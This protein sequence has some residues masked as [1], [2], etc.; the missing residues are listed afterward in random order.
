MDTK[1]QQR[2]LGLEGVDH[3][4]FWVGNA[5]AY[6]GFLAANFGFSILAYAG[7][8]TGLR[9]RASYVLQQG[10]I[11]FVVTGS[12]LPDTAI[13]DHVR[14]HGDGVR[15][16]AL[17]VR[18]CKDAY[19]QAL[20][21]GARGIAEPEEQSDEH[22]SIV[23]A[24]IA[25]YGD[26]IHTFVERSDYRGIF[27]PGYGPP[28]QRDPEGAPVDLEAI[29]HVVA[30]VPEMEPWVRYYEQIMGFSQLTH[31]TDEDVSTEYSALMSK[32]VEDGGGKIV[33]PINEPATGKRKS[34]IEE[35]LEYYRGPGVQHIAMRTDDIVS[36]VRSLRARGVRFLRVPKT[37]YDE[38]RERMTG[39]DLPWEDLAEL[40]ILVDR[41]HDGHLLQIFTEN[42]C[43]RPTVFF[44][45]IQREGSRGFGVG[46]FKA[47][48]QAI[49]R[50]QA[51]RGN[52]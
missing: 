45:I 4:E 14:L 22:G 36:A 40:G 48:F 47:L 41:D 33:L 8:E 24:S 2:T 52:L 12:L 42:V 10:E 19:A 26:T 27:A 25:A 6:A 49:E 11:R 16:V 18:D 13:A 20:E 29:D 39:V 46:N 32:V 31:F 30:N 51:D 28:R 9:D 23:T 44:E 7:Q 50:E 5:R 37:Y 1:Q 38:A 43:D 15:C 3:L 34:Q 35:Y 17:R 21:R